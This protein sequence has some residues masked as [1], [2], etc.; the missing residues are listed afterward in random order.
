V[1]IPNQVDKKKNEGAKKNDFIVRKV[2]RIIYIYGYDDGVERQQKYNVAQESPPVIS[3]TE[4]DIEIVSNVKPNRN[5]KQAALDADDRIEW[6][7][8]LEH[9]G[10]S[11]KQLVENRAQHGW[12]D[13]CQH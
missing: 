6:I 12:V 7:L 13:Q 2:V 8:S 11:V 9:L 1:T 3:F 10:Q 5:D 4:N